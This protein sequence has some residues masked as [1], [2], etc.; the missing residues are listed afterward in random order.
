MSPTAIRDVIDINL[1]GVVNGTVAAGHTMIGLGGGCIV[2]T[3][4]IA[5]A[6]GAA[7][8]A[9][10]SAS[11]GG[12]LSLTRSAAIEFAPSIRV[13]AVVPGPVRTPINEKA[14]GGPVTDADLAAIG[15]MQL[16]GRIGQPEEIAAVVAFLAS[17][18]ASFMTGAHV[19]VD[20]GMS[21]G[22]RTPG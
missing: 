5:A 8:Q 7:G 15:R 6:M 16:L 1:I 3:A 21:V 2:N 19:V 9:V 22:A 11:K 14:R 20:G 13:N 10:Y 12:V 17:D 4:S 18:D